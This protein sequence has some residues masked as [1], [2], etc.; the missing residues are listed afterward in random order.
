MIAL[1]DS[2]VNMLTDEFIKQSR[3]DPHHNA[4]T[5]Q[6]VYNQLEEWLKRSLHDNEI[7][8]EINNKGS[9]YQ[10]KINRGHFEQRSKN[11]FAR[12]K[13]ELESLVGN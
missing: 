9:V 8:M 5:E 7:L 2:W 13:A 6:Y 3:F 12:I 4:E 1:H 11:I 10:A